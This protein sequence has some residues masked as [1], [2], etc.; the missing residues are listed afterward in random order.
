[1]LCFALL[2]SKFQVLPMLNPDGVINGNY[3]ANLAGK[4]C[5]R[6]YL[7]PHQLVEPPGTLSADAALYTCASSDNF[8]WLSALH[9]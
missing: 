3:R 4:D 7:K 5:N 6:Q 9:G 2:S 8:A 1:M